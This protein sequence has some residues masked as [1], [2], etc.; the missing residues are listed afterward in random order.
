MV[1]GCEA[2]DGNFSIG[3]QQIPST[4]ASTRRQVAMAQKSPRYRGLI[5]E[6]GKAYLLPP[7]QPPV[8]AGL[9]V[10]QLE[11]SLLQQPQVPRHS[12][13]PQQARQQKPLRPT[14]A[15]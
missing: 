12:P 13:E 14:Q 15:R 2:A 3:S 6:A 10:E 1:N 8:E 7:Q 5:R 4:H 11:P 9:S